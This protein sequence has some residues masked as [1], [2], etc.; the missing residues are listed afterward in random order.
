MSVQHELSG[1]A[2]LK[3]PPNLSNALRGIRTVVQRTVRVDQ[4]E[5]GVREGEL[6]GIGYAQIR[7][8]AGETTPVRGSLN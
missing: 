2:W 6:F 3:N 7:L 8:V 4:I 1:A 5:S